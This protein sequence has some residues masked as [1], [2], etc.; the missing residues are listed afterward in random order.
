MVSRG[1]HVT[2]AFTGDPIPSG[3]RDRLLPI[4]TEASVSQDLLED[5]QNAILSYL[6]GRGYRDAQVEYQPVEQ[7]GELTLTFH[8]TQGSRYLVDRVSV[9]GNTAIATMAQR[10]SSCSNTVTTERFNPCSNSPL[11]NAPPK[12]YTTSAKILTK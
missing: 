1:P 10:S 7:N 4:R 6:R 11:A 2:I 5:S 9:N 8:V 12:S 3:D